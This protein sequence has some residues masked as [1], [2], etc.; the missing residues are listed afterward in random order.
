MIKKASKWFPFLEDK[1]EKTK[2]FGFYHA[3]GNANLF[4][5]WA[6]ADLDIE[7]TPVE[8]PGHGRRRRE[9]LP[10]SIRSLASEIAEEMNSVINDEE[11]AM[12]G[13]SMGAAV[14]YETAE[15]LDT[16]YGKRP[17]VLI[18]SARQAPGSDYKGLYR[19]CQGKDALV[20]DIAR[21]G[22]M[23]HELLESKEYLDM[24]IPLIYNDYKINE[25]YTCS[26]GRKLDIPIEANYAVGDEEARQDILCEWEQ[27]TSSF[28]IKEF[29]GDHFYIFD[30]DSA[31]LEYLEDAVNQY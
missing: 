26:A 18:V 28:K 12:W 1:K 4:I 6:K 3:G 9:P 5:K 10:K 22:L 11:F 19:C 29:E 8:L 23:P 15:I 21:L 14:A 17:K 30:H 16:V 27:Y 20:E 24:A 7:F 25:E 13:H 31:Y 2:L